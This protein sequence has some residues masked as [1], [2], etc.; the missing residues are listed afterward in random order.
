MSRQSE[1]FSFDF[2]SPQGYGDLYYAAFY[3][4]CQHEIKPVTKGHRLCLVYNLVYTE[5]PAPTASE[6]VVSSLVSSMKEW[7]AHTDSGE[8][9]PM[10]CYML[11][12]KYCEASLSFELL[13]DTDREMARVLQE[14]KKEVEFDLYV[15][16][17]EVTENWSA[18]CH[19]SDWRGIPSDDDDFEA[20]DK[21]DGIC[22][23]NNPISPEGQ[24]ISTISNF[25][26]ACCV[27]EGFFDD[28]VPDKEEVTASECEDPD[29]E[30][31]VTME[32][33]YN[34]TALLFWPTRNRIINVGVACEIDRLAQAL[35]SST[36]SREDAA[37]VARAILH[38]ATCKKRQTPH[39]LDRPPCISGEACESLLQSLLKISDARL[40]SE[41]LKVT[42]D[43]SCKSLITSNSFSDIVLA[44]GRTLGWNV[45]K[46]PLV[47]T[48]R[49]TSRCSSSIADCCKFLQ[50]V[51]TDDH[52]LDDA[53]RV[54]CRRLARI[55]VHELSHAPDS[56][57]QYIT[58]YGTGFRIGEYLLPLFAC[59]I[60][61]DSNKTLLSLVKDICTK[62]NRYPIQVTLAPLCEKF[63]FCGKNALRFLRH[64]CI[65]LV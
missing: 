31:E 27:P 48:F 45:L 19:C 9:P 22:R 10:M 33:Q 60:S 1:N 14:A 21:T 15:G 5:S 56:M 42:L 23:A 50:R 26:A 47:A 2:S 28:A 65:S 38:A 34:W 62:P 63:Y 32:R 59:L 18:E 25:E 39:Y 24:T 37:E 12:H 41:G 20:I 55:I 8:C 57:F 61:L 51:C 17:V 4:D 35:A 44:I 29:N 52:P 40:V 43:I 53:Q 16:Q 36:T 7:S 54:V 11:E 6:H 3:A 58:K 30:E 64:H 46:A 49:S 13:K